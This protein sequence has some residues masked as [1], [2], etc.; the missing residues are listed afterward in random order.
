[1]VGVA[2]RS[3]RPKRDHNL[4]PDAPDMGD[5]PPD[6]L[7]RVGIIEV[8][9]AV[10]EKLDVSNAQYLRSRQEFDSAK[11]AERLPPRIGAWITLPATLAAGCGDEVYFAPATAYVTS[12]ATSTQCLIVRMGEDTQQS[13]GF[14]DR[15][16][17][18]VVLRASAGDSPSEQNVVHE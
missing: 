1:V 6:R 10:V 15:T 18:Q 5:N 16:P 4:R 17:P 11:L 12:I 2:V 14:S 13:F 8:A 9:V 7:G 3:F